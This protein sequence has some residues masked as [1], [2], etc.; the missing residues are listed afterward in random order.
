MLNWFWQ[1]SSH[2]KARGAEEVLGDDLSADIVSVKYG[3]L[4]QVSAKIKINQAGHPVPDAAGMKGA[5][6]IVDFLKKRNERDSV[7]CLISGG[8]SAILP[9]LW[10]S[11]PR[12]W[13]GFM[14]QSPKR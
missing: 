6:E 7:I 9:Y 1:S 3:H 4:D 14:Q 11:K 13:R 12:M 8:G 10:K 2:G 5:K